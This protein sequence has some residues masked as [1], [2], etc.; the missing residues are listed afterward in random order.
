MDAQ[1]H[2]GQVS[3][4]GHFVTIT[5]SGMLAR[6]S[7][8]KGQKSIPISSITAV[9]VKAAGALTNG[10]VEFTVSGGNE[11]RSRAGS[12]TLDASRNENAVLFTKRQSAEMAALA[13]AVRRA[14]GSAHAPV[15]TSSLGDELAK[16]GQLLEQGLLTRD[17]FD[18]QKARLLAG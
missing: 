3:F 10:F 5:R 6:A 4:D 12:Q 2:N 13:D 9:Q 16:L 14:I 15:A 18:A 17:E 7:V 1:G 11:V 8:G